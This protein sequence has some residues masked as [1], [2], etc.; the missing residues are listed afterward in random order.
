MQQEY[1]LPET[2][3][4]TGIVVTIITGI[5]GITGITS[6]QEKMKNQEKKFFLLIHYNKT[7]I[8]I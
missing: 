3:M 8:N 6:H 7:N 4:V 1:S 2:Y 5:P